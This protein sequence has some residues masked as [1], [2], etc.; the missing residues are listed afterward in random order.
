MAG[1]VE[2]IFVRVFET[3]QDFDDKIIAPQKNSCQG[4]VRAAAASASAPAKL[5]P[6]R[7]A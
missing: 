1:L 7:A 5:H 4:N 6:V 3:F 2:E